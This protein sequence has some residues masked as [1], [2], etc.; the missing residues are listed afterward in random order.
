VADDLSLPPRLRA[1]TRTTRCWSL[2]PCRS[3]RPAFAVAVS[4][5]RPR[6]SSRR[7]CD[8]LFLVERSGPARI[9]APWRA[10]ACANCATGV[11]HI[12]PSQRADL[13]LKHRELMAQRQHFGAPHRPERGLRGRNNDRGDLFPRPLRRSLLPYR[14]A[15]WVG[16]ILSWGRLFLFRARVG[17]AAVACGLTL[18]LTRL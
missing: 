4:T 2:A 13:A 9:P 12:C 7:S 10:L 15:E 18:C 14:A 11:L 3:G 8:E 1:A 17:V 16:L 6:L 5:G